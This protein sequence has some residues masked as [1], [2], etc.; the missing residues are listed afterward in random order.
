V[1]VLYYAMGGGHG[2]AAR[3]LAVLR[4]LPPGAGVLVAPAAAGSWAE[5]EGVTHLAPPPRPSAEELAAFVAGAV[6]RLEPELLLIDVFPR[7]VLGEL[8]PI[9]AATRAPCW[10][11]SRWV[12]PA[13]YL[14]PGVRASLEERYERILWCEAP[15]VELEALRLPASRLPPVL[16]RAR[17]ECL[18]REEARRALGA[19]GDAPLVLALPSGDPALQEELCRLLRKVCA[20]VAPA[21]RLV[22]ISAELPARDEPGLR[23]AAL[24]PAVRALAAADLL[25]CA[26]GYHAVHEAR[27]HGLV[28]IHLPQRRVY[29][30]QHRRVAGSLV[31]EEPAQLEALVACA[32]AQRAVALPQRAAPLPPAAED[33]ASALAALVDARLGARA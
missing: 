19:D 10:L 2:H 32:L 6:S 25:V 26:G 11:V 21:A 9:L 8:P 3:G 16:L 24:Y 30:D 7:G 12:T 28:A 1:R 18:A 13:Y 4:R 29:D 31:A 22:A 20:R 27:L 17:G 23:V 15:P 5:R 33:G 14:D